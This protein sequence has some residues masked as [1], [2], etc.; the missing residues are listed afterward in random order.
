MEPLQDLLEVLGGGGGGS[1]FGGGGG[2][3]GTIIHVE[4]QVAVYPCGGGMF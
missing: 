1:M 3:D 4:G 2:V